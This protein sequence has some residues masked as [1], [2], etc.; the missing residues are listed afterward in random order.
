MAIA[1]GFAATSVPALVTKRY[2]S[3]SNVSAIPAVIDS[4][5][6]KTKQFQATLTKIYGSAFEKVFQ[7]KQVRSGKGK[8]RSRKY[9]SNAGLLIVTGKDENARFS[10]L[11]VKSVSEVR[12][13]DLYPLGRLTLYT[14]KALEEIKHVA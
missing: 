8:K 11:D 4:L 3:L 6:A 9:K 10:G 14:Q 5:P 2:A 1:S 12:M 7:V 13:K